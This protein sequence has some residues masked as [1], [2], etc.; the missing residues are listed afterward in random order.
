[1]D[2]MW[3][4]LNTF[5][6]DSQKAALKKCKEL[7][8]DPD[9]GEVPLQE[10]LINLDSASKTLRD[11]IEKKKLIQL[12]LSVQKNLLIK[13]E[14][15]GKYLASLN[16]G[17]DEV[18]NLVNSIEELNTAV[19]QYGLHNLSKEVLGYE[20][21]MNQLKH[22]EV[23]LKKLRDEL[24]GGLKL[25]ADIETLINETRAAQALI[26]TAAND[27]TKV[28]TD[29]TA[30]LAQINERN[31]S[32]AALAATT[33]QSE[34]TTTQLAATAKAS[35]AEVEALEAKIKE[36]FAEIDTYRTKISAAS[37]DARKNVDANRL[38]TKTLVD[39]L[40]GLEVQIRDKIIQATGF[41]LFNSFQTRKESIVRSKH[42]WGVALGLLI[43]VSIACTFYIAT[44]TT[45]FNIGFY[46]KLSVSL[47]LL[48][49]IS[50]CTLQY[51]RERRL[52]EEYAFKSAIS[53]SLEPYRDL[54]SK[55]VEIEIPQERERF[56][57]FILESI[58][59]IFTS[60]MHNIFE[61]KDRTAEIVDKT[62]DKAAKIAGAV[63]KAAK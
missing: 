38:E 1:M 61:P 51:S 26:E 47:P 17:A 62:L 63:A 14:N 23:Q 4:V 12:P 37:D 34:T 13:L 35:A 54:V 56:A 40:E 5:S 58:R 43:A 59:L 41:S 22:E 36:F 16:S 45:E 60:P 55:F 28:S 7:E 49:G 42:F 2:A 24:E 44:H 27:T 50:F 10:S 11:A 30:I 48:F 29:A 15:V 53:L 46:L 21:K 8:L 52:E 19:W 20:T 3:A 33:T 57:T 9:K 31:Q 32:T 18:I 25:K 6:D 39:N